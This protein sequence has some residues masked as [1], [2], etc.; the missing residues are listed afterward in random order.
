MSILSAAPAASVLDSHAPADLRALKIERRESHGHRIA[1][2]FTPS[3]HAE[4]LEAAARL[5]ETRLGTVV[6]TLALAMARPL[7]SK[8]KVR[9]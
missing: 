8:S 9:G 5:G 3:E 7:N 2:Y 6:R 1:V 4:V